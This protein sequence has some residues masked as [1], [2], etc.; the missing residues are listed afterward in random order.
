MVLLGVR[1]LLNSKMS[2]LSHLAM[3]FPGQGSQSVGM[4]AD[5][6]VPFP[7]VQDTFAEA[8]AVLGYDLWQLVQNGPAE[9]LDQTMHTQPALLA[10]S[11]AV[12]RIL[13]SRELMIP[14]LLAGH[15]LGEYTALVCANALTFHDAIRV[16]AARGQFMQEAVPPGVG[17]MAALIGLDEAAVQTICREAVQ[18]ADELVAPANFNSIGQI[19]VAGH[20]AAVERAVALAKTHGAKLAMMIPVSVPSHCQLMRPAAQRLSELLSTVTIQL[21]RIPVINNVDVKEYTSVDAI[22]EGLVKQLY[23][24]V[25]WVETIQSFVQQGITEVI[26]CGP[27]KILT[28]LNKRI[29]KVLK[30]ISA[31][32]V[33]SV[34][35]IIEVCN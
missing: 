35:S 11:Y 24:P 31:S 13:Q 18:S 1:H 9:V 16:V 3:V 5:L 20:K 29:D 7:E 26:E 19:V 32:D 2:Q 4:L 28:G 6:A 25:R 12:W 33:S 14:A 17:A 34:Q 23:Y 30:L 22:R 21:P 8:S 27:G 15:S 10:A